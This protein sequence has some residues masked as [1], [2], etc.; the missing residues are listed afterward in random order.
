MTR[1]VGSCVCGFEASS[2]MREIGRHDVSSL[3]DGPPLAALM[4]RLLPEPG[5]GAAP[6]AQSAQ[7]GAKRR[8]A[9]GRLFC[10][11]MQSGPSFG[12]RRKINGPEPLPSARGSGFLATLKGARAGFARARRHRTAGSAAMAR[13]AKPG[14]AEPPSASETGAVFRLHLRE[15]P[16]LHG[17]R[18]GCADRH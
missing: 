2:W 12:P 9:R 14:A 4:A 18:T 11:A 6:R 3:S 7:A 5:A 17:R 10:F 16:R 1:A 8:T 15:H 13:P